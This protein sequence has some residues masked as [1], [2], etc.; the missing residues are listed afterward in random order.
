MSGQ[1]TFL[2]QSLDTPADTPLVALRHQYHLYSPIVT[3]QP[4]LRLPLTYR[5]GVRAIEATASSSIELA[6]ASKN[7][8]GEEKST[9]VNDTRTHGTA[10]FGTG[11][12]V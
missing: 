3:L 6:N 2:R 9:N 5:T 8:R 11:S 12:F 7:S 10:G 4:L 1:G